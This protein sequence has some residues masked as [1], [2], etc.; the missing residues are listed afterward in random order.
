MIIKRSRD[1]CMLLPSAGAGG[2]GLWDWWRRNCVIRLLFPR[3]PVKHMFCCLAL[4]CLFVFSIGEDTSTTQT[5]VQ[6][7]AVVGTGVISLYGM[8]APC[9]VRENPQSPNFEEVVVLFLFDIFFNACSSPWLVKAF[10][11]A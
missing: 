8:L 5:G 6:S 9:W 3:E 1:V 10:V 2:P 7:M 4:R 11:R